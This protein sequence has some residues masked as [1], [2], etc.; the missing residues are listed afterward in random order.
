MDVLLTN[1]DGI[2]ASGILALYD[3]F[4]R[5]HRVTVVAPD[6]EKSAVG[7][8]LTL[9]VPIRAKKVKMKNGETGYAVSGT[10]ADCIKLSMLDLLDNKPDIVISGINRGANTG[11]NIN[12]SGTAAAAREAT[13]YSIPAIAASVKGQS[14]QNYLD[15][16]Q[17]IHNLSIE[18]FEKGLPLGSFLNVNLPDSPLCQISG[19]R[20]CKQSQTFPDEFIDKRK[21]PR[22]IN[23][24]W[25][26]CEF[27]TLDKE[28]DMDAVAIDENHISITPI[29]CDMTDYDMLAS[30][31]EWEMMNMENGLKN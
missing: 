10:P 14:P 25:H 3:V 23:Y 1:D 4:S 22:G 20:I 15:A 27:T 16:A 30:L 18:V 28:K 31:K 9:S 24:Y 12:Y 29:R 21:D 8:G 26:G 11:V 5:H 19:V 6:S 2:K 7:H 17:F 13:L